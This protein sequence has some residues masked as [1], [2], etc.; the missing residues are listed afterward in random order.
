MDIDSEKARKLFEIKKNQIKMVIRR[1]YDASDEEPLLD[2]KVGNF[3]D[4]YVP[5]A[6]KYKKSVREVLSK[7]YKNENDESLYVFFA[8]ISSN[9]QL[10]VE[11]INNVLSEMK[12]GK[13]AIIIT[14]I[15]LSASA[16][17]KIL[18]LLTYN[19]YIF[20][21]TEMGYDPTEHFLVPKHRVLGVKEQRDFLIK[22]GLTVDQ[23]PTILTTDIIARYYGFK[24]GQVVEIIR[25][26]FYDSITQESLGY[27]LVKEDI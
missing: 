18:G 24:P 3:L 2:Y 8:D 7:T 11:V 15:P 4:F 5:I 23:F 1:G 14:P 20:M 17:K 10:G 25:T 21:E 19:I 22:N 16:K 6:K 26:N 27:R 12:K 9:K 13:N